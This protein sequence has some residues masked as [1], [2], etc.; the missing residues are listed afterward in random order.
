[1]S[2]VSSCLTL[3]YK[4]TRTEFLHPINILLSFNGNRQLVKLSNLACGG[5][6]II[7]RFIKITPGSSVNKLCYLY[8]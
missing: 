5:L 3:P 7:N 6:Y 1:M 4:Q 2:T 8:K